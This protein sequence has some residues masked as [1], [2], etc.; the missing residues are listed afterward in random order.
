M[1]LHSLLCSF[2]AI[3]LLGGGVAGCSQQA[4]DPPLKGASIGGPLNLINQDGQRISDS[5][6]AGKY[7]LVYFGFA[8]CPDVC[9]VDLAVLGAGLR[10]F[11]AEDRARAE[12][13]QPIFITVDPR[14]DTPQVLK[15][16][17][18]NFHPRLIGL[19]G[20]EQEIQQVVT[21]HGGSALPD[22]P[23]E[24]GG[25]NVNHTRFLLLMGPDNAP[26]AIVPH[27]EGAEG[28]ARAL[29]QWVR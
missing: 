6:F 11:E 19:T 21:A 28:L 14:R 27:D 5:S 25:Y 17:V 29:D 16:Y 23:N 8:N 22:E 26:I 10:Q 12:R 13:V 7:R 20:S 15:R 24:A 4:A 2:L 18:A 9:P 3:L 1:N